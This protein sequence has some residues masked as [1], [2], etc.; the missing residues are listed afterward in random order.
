M[1]VLVSSF[2]FS[3]FS[4]RRF[5]VMSQFKLEVLPFHYTRYKN[6]R[7]SHFNFLIFRFM[8]LFILQNYECVIDPQIKPIEYLIT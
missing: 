5:L 6:T 8:C 3:G 4:P 7:I 2:A 1:M